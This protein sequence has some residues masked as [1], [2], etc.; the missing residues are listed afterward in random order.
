MFFFN[1]KSSQM[2]WSAP[3][4]S[5]EYLC[6]GSTSTRNILILSVRGPSLYVRICRLQ[7]LWTFIHSR[8]GVYYILIH[9]IVNFHIITLWDLYT[10]QR[11]GLHTIVRGITKYLPRH[12][13]VP[14][15]RA[16]N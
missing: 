12:A 14:L 2:S 13:T 7:T 5:I 15:M 6:Y 8:E 11:G 3:V 10:Y 4:D 1:L 9:T 16:L